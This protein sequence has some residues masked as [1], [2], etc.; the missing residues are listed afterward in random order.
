MYR[1]GPPH[2]LWLTDGLEFSLHPQSSHLAE[3]SSIGRDVNLPV[4]SLSRQKIINSISFKLLIK[5]KCQTCPTRCSFNCNLTQWD[6]LFFF[7]FFFLQ[8]THASEKFQVIVSGSDIAAI[9]FSSLFCCDATKELPQ[10]LSI[11]RG[12][13]RNGVCHQR[14]MRGVTRM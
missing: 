14:E 10:T 4:H 3:C 12:Q 1:G 13:A 5:E 8:Q 6:L 7:S 2:T 11:T 9:V